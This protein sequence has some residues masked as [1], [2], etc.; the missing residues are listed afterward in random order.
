[1]N[2][3]YEGIRDQFKRDTYTHNLI[4]RDGEWAIFSKEREDTYITYELHRIRIKKA[5]KFGPKRE[6]L[7]SSGEFGHCGWAY[8]TLDRA[9]EKLEEK[10]NKAHI[11]FL[12][13]SNTQVV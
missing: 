12:S 1:M 7:A 13:D 10:K 8:G 3:D 2:K 11:A 5:D 6:V 9:M 4:Y